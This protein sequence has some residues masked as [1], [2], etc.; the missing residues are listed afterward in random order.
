MRKKISLLLIASL[1]IS[2]S[3][4]ASATRMRQNEKEKLENAQTV[5]EESGKDWGNINYVDNLP[6][7]DFSG[8]SYGGVPV[9]VP[10]YNNYKDFSA[11]DITNFSDAIVDMKGWDA[12]IGAIDYDL[13]DNILN[14]TPIPAA[15]DTNKTVIGYSRKKFGW[16]DI[17]FKL[18]INDETDK[19]NG[20]VGLTVLADKT[21]AVQWSGVQGYLIVMKKNSVELQKYFPGQEMLG[22]YEHDV[23]KLDTWHEVDLQMIP[24]GEALRLK[25]IV[26]GVTIFEYLDEKTELVL[27]EGYVNFYTSMTGIDLQGH[28]AKISHDG[29]GNSGNESG[30]KKETEL[31]VLKPGKN[32]ANKDGENV[33]IDINDPEVAPVIENNRVMLP[34]RFLSESI[35]ASVSWDEETRTANIS[36]KGKTVSVVPGFAEYTINGKTYPMDT[37]AKIENGRILVPVRMISEALDKRVLWENEMVWLSDYEYNITEETKTKVEEMLK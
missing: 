11:G 15:T 28:E 2:I 29:A 16:E 19:Y 34:L 33:L 32:T 8:Y 20:W 23:I 26:D 7:P 24:E 35:G 1:V 17:K 21:Q 30:E 3:T 25:F 27:K 13:S 5:T 36:K 14:F 31:I 18:K 22:I 4:N 10:N 37:P 9:E 12:L 6:G